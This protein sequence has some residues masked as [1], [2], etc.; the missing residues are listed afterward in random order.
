MNKQLWKN[1]ET[2]PKFGMLISVVQFEPIIQF[3][4]TGSPD[5]SQV[6]SLLR[7]IIDWPKQSSPL[8]I[9]LKDL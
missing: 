9:C 1:I 7:I 6:V 4:A 8:N 3:F 5:L 2:S